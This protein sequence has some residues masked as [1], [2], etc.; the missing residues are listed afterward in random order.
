MYRITEETLLNVPDAPIK[1]AARYYGAAF[2]IIIL[3]IISH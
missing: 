1:N 2:F 3:I